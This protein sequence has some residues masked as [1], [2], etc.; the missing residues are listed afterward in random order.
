MSVISGTTAIQM[1]NLASPPIV[2][3]G[4]AEISMAQSISGVMYNATTAEKNSQTIQNTVVSQCCALM[5][6]GGAA[7]ATKPAKPAKG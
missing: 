3:V 6:S 5:V 1:I 2:S 7:E 4:M